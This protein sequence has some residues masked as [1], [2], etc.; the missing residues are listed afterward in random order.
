M[1]NLFIDSVYRNQ[2][3]KLKEYQPIVF[4]LIKHKNILQLFNEYSFLDNYYQLQWHIFY[5]YEPVLKIYNDIEN[6][7][8]ITIKMTAIIGYLFFIGNKMNINLLDKSTNEI[9]PIIDKYISM[10]TFW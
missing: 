7:D 2:L 4:Y 8:N 1:A 10:K 5:G 9:I 3:N 6:I